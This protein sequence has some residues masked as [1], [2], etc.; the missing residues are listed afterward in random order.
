MKKRFRILGLAL[1]A[2]M[3]LGAASGCASKAPVTPD[4]Y[5]CTNSGC[6]GI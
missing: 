1:T 5:G 4:S 3:A 2:V 6:K